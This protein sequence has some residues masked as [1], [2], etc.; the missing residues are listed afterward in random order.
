MRRSTNSRARA[1]ACSRARW[2]TRLVDALAPIQ[3][4]YEELRA[5]EAGLYRVLA[6]SAARVRLVADA[7]LHRVQE[8]V[9]LR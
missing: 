5:D 4:R 3:H 8:A 2:P 6:D 1:T 9:G 7:T